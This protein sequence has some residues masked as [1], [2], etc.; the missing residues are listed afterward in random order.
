[1]AVDFEVEVNRPQGISTSINDIQIPPNQGD[2]YSWEWIH[3]PVNGPTDVRVS[4]PGPLPEG[5][6][7]KFG[8]DR[9]NGPWEDTIDLHFDEGSPTTGFWIF[10][11]VTEGYVGGRVPLQATL[12]FPG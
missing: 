4:I 8:W 11:S 10:V 6:T 7:V 1:M 3:A 9:E 5:T 12:V 2:H